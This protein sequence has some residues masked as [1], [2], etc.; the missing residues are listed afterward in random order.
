[1]FGFSP[2]SIILIFIIIVGIILFLKINPINKNLKHQPI[3]FNNEINNNE[4]GI[5]SKSISVPSSRFGDK[6]ILSAYMAEVVSE[7]QIWTETHIVSSGGGGYVHPEHG[8]HVSAPSISSGV[9]ERQRY[10]VKYKN[11]NEAEIRD[12]VGTRKGH[13][14]W[15]IFGGFHRRDSHLIATYNLD[16]RKYL[17]ENSRY[18]KYFFW[19]YLGWLKLFLY[20][21]SIMYVIPAIFLFKKIKWENAVKD[22]LDY[23]I[24]DFIKA[25]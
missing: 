8:G 9:I 19:T 13:K 5:I 3:D 15:I 12:A 2:I 11:G 16:T 25:L 14:L 6:F 17:L 1:M 21:L 18:K 24:D 22:K 7:S 10:F 23:A 4:N 20:V